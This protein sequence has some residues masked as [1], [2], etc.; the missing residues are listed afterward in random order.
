MQANPGFK[1]QPLRI[2]LKHFRGALPVYNGEVVDQ[3]AEQQHIA[4]ALDGDGSSFEA[5]LAEVLVPGHRFACAL[6]HDA[7]LA[8]DA[9]QDAAVLAWRNLRRLK[10]ERSFR[11]WFLGIV[12][13]RCRDQMRGRWWHLIQTP[14]PAV[15]SEEA[16]EHAALQRAELREALTKLHGRERQVLALRV[17]LELPWGDVAA[18]T[19]LTEAG[20]RTAYYRALARLRPLYS[21]TEVTT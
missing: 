17:Y 1:S 6:L 15:K 10:P 11:P 4:R 12:A 16:P 20:A 19:H 5:L 9:V 21:A 3:A 18:I 13:H 8:E 14:L 2:T 7:A